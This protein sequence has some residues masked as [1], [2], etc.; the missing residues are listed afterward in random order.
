MLINFAQFAKECSVECLEFMTSREDNVVN[1][2]HLLHRAEY[3]SIGVS[4]FAC[5]ADFMYGYTIYWYSRVLV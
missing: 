3:T 4:I 1:I 2:L 5:K